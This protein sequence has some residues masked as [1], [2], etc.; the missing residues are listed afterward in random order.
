MYLCV[1]VCVCLQSWKRARTAEDLGRKGF[2]PDAPPQPEP[3]LPME[4]NGNGIRSRHQR[5][6]IYYTCS[7][8]GCAAKIEK[9]VFLGEKPLVLFFSPFLL[10]FRTLLALTGPAPSRITILLFTTVA[11]GCSPKMLRTKKKK[12]VDITIA[13]IVSQL[14]VGCWSPKPSQGLTSGWRGLRSIK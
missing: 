10:Y 8:F 1:C 6:T 5:R 9:F 13:D 11:R 3:L 12:N 7:V 2:S 14:G 4:S